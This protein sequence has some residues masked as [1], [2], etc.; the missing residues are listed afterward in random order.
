MDLTLA[1]LLCLEVTEIFT[2]RSM[3]SSWRSR[4]ATVRPALRTGRSQN[5]GVPRKTRIMASPKIGSRMTMKVEKTAT[6]RIFLDA[7]D[8][9]YGAVHTRASPLV[10]V[11][12][13]LS[14][15]SHRRAMVSARI[16][17]VADEPMSPTVQV[18]TVTSED[19]DFSRRKY[20]QYSQRQRHANSSKS[21]HSS[22]DVMRPSSY[23]SRARMVSKDST[24][25]RSVPVKNKRVSTTLTRA[26]QAETAW[27]RMSPESSIDSSP[28]RPKI[29]RSR[30]THTPMRS[31][32]SFQSRRRSSSSHRRTRQRDLTKRSNDTRSVL[33]ER[34]RISP[35]PATRMATG[36]TIGMTTGSATGMT[37]GMIPGM[38]Q[39]MTTSSHYCPRNE[40]RRI[41]C[42]QRQ[43][44][45]TPNGYVS[46]FT[47]V[48][49]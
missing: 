37:P 6:G 35:S 41:S 4:S 46:I 45:L 28:M 43:E 25:E 38:A 36:M 27:K 17:P 7:S 2:A 16:F 44:P 11:R 8:P 42:L 22:R 31:V 20:Y 23:R 26:K 34:R 30:R 40:K 9:R 14:P 32:D 33:G 10:D 1:F 12:K 13:Q 18:T 24:R 21:S 15:S 29:I 3:P 48:Y 19:K 47:N 39:G 5:A 49:K